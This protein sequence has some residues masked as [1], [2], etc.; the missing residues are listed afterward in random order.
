MTTKATSTRK[1]PKGTTP[2]DVPL[3]HYN[4][5]ETARFLGVSRRWLA[6]QAAARAIRCT[7]I[8]GNLRFT[9]EH[10]SEISR[11]GEV[12]PSTYGRTAVA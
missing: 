4:V 3:Q 10:I 11:A 5:D 12:D 7:Y 9:A 8:A 6:G 1:T 2:G